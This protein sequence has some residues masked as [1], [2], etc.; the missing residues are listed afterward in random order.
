LII[1][2]VNEELKFNAGIHG[3]KIKNSIKHNNTSASNQ[4][5]NVPMFGSPDQYS[6]LSAKD[7]EDLTRKMMGKHKEWQKAK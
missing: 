4:N 3:A 1:K 5:A 6:H 2:Q 7:R